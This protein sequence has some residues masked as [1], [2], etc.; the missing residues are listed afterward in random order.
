MPT[1]SKSVA[2][3][4]INRA[5]VLTLWAAVV[6]ERL[7][8]TW[9]EAVT[10]GRAVAGL[11]AASKAQ[12]IGLAE[13]KRRAPATK[14]A[15]R[16]AREVK[17]K[18]DADDVVELLGRNV[19]VLKTPDG[20]RAATDGRPTSPE[21]VHRYLE[22]KFGDGLRPARAAMTALARSRKPAALASEGFALY[23]DFRPN[24]PRGVKGWGAKG[25]LDLDRIRA[26]AEG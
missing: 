19:P 5:P 15:A 14:S 11:N 26:M 10:F 23:E 16:R 3:I 13:P 17:Q 20:L 25:V 9:D 1:R 18:H 24:I 2:T 21:S 12:I 4:S 6:A 7:G 8:Y 22:E